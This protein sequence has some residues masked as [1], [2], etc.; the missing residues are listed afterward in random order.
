VDCALSLLIAGCRNSPSGWSSTPDSGEGGFLA[1]LIT[2]ETVDGVV[3]RLDQV[4]SKVAR[5][6]TKPYLCGSNERSALSELEMFLNNQHDLLQNEFDP[7]DIGDDSQAK[8]ILNRIYSMIINPDYIINTRSENI[9]GSTAEFNFNINAEFD[10]FMYM[11]LTNR[12][13]LAKLFW[14]RDGRKN[15][16]KMFQSA[17]LACL[18]CRGLNKLHFVKQH[19]HLVTAFEHVADYYEGFVAKVLDQ[20]Y[21]Q[22]AERTLTA[23]GQK[24]QQCRD[25]NTLDIIVHAECNKVV[26][27]CGDLCIEA[28]NRRFFG[29]S[30]FK[31]SFSRLVLAWSSV[32]EEFTSQV[33]LLN[34]FK[35]VS[36]GHNSNE[37]QHKLNLMRNTAG[38]V[39]TDSTNS[40]SIMIFFLCVFMDLLGNYLHFS[41][42]FLW[43]AM[44]A[45]ASGI[46][47]LLSQK[48]PLTATFCILENF[49]P[50]VRSLPS[51][52]GSWWL[53]ESR[54]WI[55]RKSKSILDGDELHVFLPID[56]F[57]VDAI[58]HL[59]A[60]CLIT[61]FLLMEPSASSS[62]LEVFIMVLLVVDEVPD[63]LFAGVKKNSMS[64]LNVVIDGFGDY[65][66][67]AGYE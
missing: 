54:R 1:R 49:I 25:W 42:S 9:S 65:W 63:I 30:D 37:S 36:E 51:V 41:Y 14:V 22:N 10:L 5:K 57:L 4:L 28:V 31:T 20:A 48:C 15:T 38:R 3:L 61:Y 52:S 66:Q 23:I 34:F 18:I 59:A 40:P 47:V 55:D 26:E 2:S 45:L 43:Q 58:S 50:F 56:Y 44:W 39:D 29:A 67:S 16:A 17:L 32:V 46:F 60:T 7:R 62:V 53:M 24:Y 6:S 21:A 19:Y 11:V 27:T 35:K 8:A 12:P 64:M 13:S 33:P